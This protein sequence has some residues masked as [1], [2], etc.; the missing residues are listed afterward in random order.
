MIKG[1]G[2]IRD[3]VNDQQGNG[4][5]LVDEV[6]GTVSITD[7]YEGDRSDRP[8]KA[9]GP[10]DDFLALMH[11]H[12]AGFRSEGGKRAFYGHGSNPGEVVLG[13]GCNS[14]NSAEAL[15][16]EE[17]VAAINVGSGQNI[18]DGGD[19]ILIDA[20]T[21]RSALRIPESPIVKGKNIESVPW[22]PVD[23]S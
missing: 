3:A 2:S 5:Y 13:H 17:H 11:H 1:D 15:T 12:I 9:G 19:G 22:K 16:V 8:G 23:V 14:E 18:L 21:M 20:G 10:A 7:P 6:N 4:R